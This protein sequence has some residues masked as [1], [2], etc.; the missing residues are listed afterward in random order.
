V[1]S[2]LA[3]ATGQPWKASLTLPAACTTLAPA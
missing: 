2:V 3:Q 1:E